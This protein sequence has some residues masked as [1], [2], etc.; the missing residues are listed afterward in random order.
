MKNNG[1]LAESSDPGAELQDIVDF[2]N[3][4]ESKPK[5][6]GYNIQSY[7]IPVLMHQLTKFGLLDDFSISISGFI[8][9]LKLSK[10]TFCKS[11]TENFKQGTLVKTFLGKQ[12]EAH[13]ALADVRALKELFEAKL[14]PFCGTVDVFTFDYYV[15]KFSLKPLIKTKP[16]L[17][18]TLQ[19]LIENLLSLPRLRIIYRR[20]PDNDIRNVFTEPVSGNLSKPRIS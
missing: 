3:F 10:R 15:I 2:I 18:I 19:K 11:D 5:I 4:F 12:H 8:D 17:T 13:N 16:I 20:D 7:D 14:L 9:T 6:L 1:T